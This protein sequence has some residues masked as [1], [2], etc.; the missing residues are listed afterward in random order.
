MSVPCRVLVRLYHEKEWV[1]NKSAEDHSFRQ[2]VLCPVSGAFWVYFLSELR[3]IMDSEHILLAKKWRLAQTRKD[4]MLRSFGLFCGFLGMAAFEALVLL[5]MTAIIGAYRGSVQIPGVGL[6]PGEEGLAYVVSYIKYAVG[7]AS[8][9][10]KVFLVA[11]AML[12]ALA[13]SGVAV[14]LLFW[15]KIVRASRRARTIIVATAERPLPGPVV[16]S[17]SKDLAQTPESGP[18]SPAPLPP[19]FF[20][21]QTMLSV[22]AGAGVILAILFWRKLARGPRKRE[23]EASPRPASQTQG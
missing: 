11:L 14:P 2:R 22:L 12:C 21:G 17:P 15:G 16:G 13:A 23:V 4:A 20:L 6:P 19:P 7:A 8:L 10:F 1:G 18:S 9:H 5:A 3:F